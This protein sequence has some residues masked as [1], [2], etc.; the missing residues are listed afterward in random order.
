MHRLRPAGFAALALLAAAGCTPPQTLLPV[1]GTVTLDG[2]PFGDGND[3]VIRFEPTDGQGNSAESFITAGKFSVQ[4]TPGTYKAS[5]TWS[6]KTGKVRQGV[7]GPGSGVEVSEQVIPTKYNT[8]T[9]LRA[10]VT[11]QKTRHDFAISSK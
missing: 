3:A 9:E 1:T 7:A 8:R 4:L 11:S 5:I 6:K 10:E 2:Q